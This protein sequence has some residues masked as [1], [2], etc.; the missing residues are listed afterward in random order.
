MI[1]WLRDLM[2]TVTAE[3]LSARGVR[4]LAFMALVVPFG[5]LALVLRWAPIRRA[6]RSTRRIR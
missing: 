3:D 2:D 5:W 4:V 6:V 1:P